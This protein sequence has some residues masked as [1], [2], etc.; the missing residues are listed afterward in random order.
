[1]VSLELSV[2]IPKRRCV[3]EKA[4][5][6]VRWDALTAVRGTGAGASIGEYN[7]AR[8]PLLLQRPRTFG[9]ISARLVG[10]R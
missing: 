2:L 9:R 7:V 1:M 10:M 3:H 6:G 4:P 5:A 8:R